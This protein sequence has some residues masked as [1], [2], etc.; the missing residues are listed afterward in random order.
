MIKRRL[1]SEYADLLADAWY[2]ISA[3]PLFLN[4]ILNL[5]GLWFLHRLYRVAILQRI[6][7]PKF[8]TNPL[9]NLGR[10][11]FTSNNFHSVFGGA[12][13]GVV[14][15]LVYYNVSIQ[16]FDGAYY[17]S[18]GSGTTQAY[19]Q[20]NS[21]VVVVVEADPTL[22]LLMPS[23]SLQS[24]VGTETKTEGFVEG[25]VRAG[26]IAPQTDSITYTVTTGIFNGQFVSPLRNP[27]RQLLTT[28]YR[29]GHPGV[30]LS[31]EMG[32]PLYAVADGVVVSTGSGIWA[33]GKIV[34]IDHGDGWK[35]MY[36]HMSRIDVKPG[37]YVTQNS[38]IGAV[39]STGNST[40]PHVHLEIHKDGRPQNPVGTVTGI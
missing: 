33:Y 16:R 34:T 27:P 15:L 29:S 36:A 6:L 14:F 35:S 9:S 11:M 19:A 37:D 7:T 32:T 8:G 4:H 22:D 12:L 10:I 30:D 23:S 5:V 28:T 26:Y 13:A 38:V 40:G 3:L 18:I 2:V 31:T 25:R 17:V 39:G 1:V 24:S 20:D 21:E